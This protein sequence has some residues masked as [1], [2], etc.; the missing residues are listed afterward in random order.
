MIVAILAADMA[1]ARTIVIDAPDLEH[2]NVA[3]LLGPFKPTLLSP[4][5]ARGLRGKVTL[6]SPALDAAAGPSWQLP[7]WRKYLA[8]LFEASPHFAYFLR[9]D[10]QR[11]VE[12]VLAVLPRKHLAVD[13]RGGLLP[14]GKVL[15]QV[16]ATLLD[17]VAAYATAVGDDRRAVIAGLL[18]GFGPIGKSLL[19]FY[20]E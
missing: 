1:A 8:L 12:I 10:G 2:K 17:P 11:F 9:S 6:T 5:R 4:A 13:A 3:R 15:A 16:L 20:E 7:A 18:A 14:D 19:P